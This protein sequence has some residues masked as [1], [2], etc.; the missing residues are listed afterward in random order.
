[1]YCPKC[2]NRLDDGQT[3]CPYCP[4]AP[5]PAIN[6]WLVPSILVTAFCCQPLGVVAL[7]FAALA[8]GHLSSGRYEEAARTASMAGKWLMWALIAG[9]T[10]WFIWGGF[11]LSMAL[12]GAFSSI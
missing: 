12:L 7:V 4:A 5:A 8:T 1:M 9:L 6:T 10:F 11:Y 2:G 3:E